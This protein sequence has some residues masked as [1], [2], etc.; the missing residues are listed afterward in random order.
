MLL[1]KHIL[2]RQLR[3]F[4]PNG[5]QRVRGVLC[6]APIGRLACTTTPSSRSF[7]FALRFIRQSNNVDESCIKDGPDAPVRAIRLVGLA[8]RNATRLSSSPLPYEFIPLMTTLPVS[9]RCIRLPPP[10]KGNAGYFRRALCARLRLA[11]RRTSSPVT[12]PGASPPTSRSCRTCSAGGQQPRLLRCRRPP[13]YRTRCWTWIGPRMPPVRPADRVG[14]RWS[15]PRP[16]SAEE[17][18]PGGRTS[19]MS[20]SLRS[21]ERALN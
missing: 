20:S 10:A 17:R 19:R 16:L 12:R 2:C 5:R 7:Y 11:R 18:V 14:R 4:Y 9:F 8:S 13:S 15:P 6:L 1:K 21:T 3:L